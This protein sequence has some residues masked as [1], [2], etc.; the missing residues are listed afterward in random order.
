V[1]IPNGWR[2][3]EV[4]VDWDRL[5]EYAVDARNPGDIADVSLEGARVAVRDAQRVLDAVLSDL[6][7]GR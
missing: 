6:K 3:K 5:T 4:D 7:Y 1:T 2:V